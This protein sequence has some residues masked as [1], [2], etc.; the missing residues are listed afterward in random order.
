MCVC[1]CVCVCVR[2]EIIQLFCI[3]QESVAQPCFKFAT[4]VVLSLHSQTHNFL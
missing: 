4:K 2:F 3:F 1:V